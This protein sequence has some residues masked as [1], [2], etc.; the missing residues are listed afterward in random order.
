LTSITGANARTFSYN[1]AGGYGNVTSNGLQDF[2]YNLA[3]QMTG[4][5]SPTVAYQYDGNSRR[6][7]RTEGGQTTYT[8]YSQ[9]GQLLHKEAGGVGT[10][11]MYAGHM[12]VAT[13][14]GSTVNYVHMDL[15][16]S[17]IDGRAGSTN[18]T[19]NYTPWGEKLDNPIPLAGDVGYTGHQSDVATGLTYM[20]ARY[21]D[22]VVGRFM[23]VDP[24]GFS[25][26]DPM[27]FNRYSYANN[28]PY[29]YTDP[30]GMCVEDACVL[31]AAAVRAAVPAVIAA[32]AA[33]AATPVM[34]DLANKIGDAITGNNVGG[35][36]NES[37]PEGGNTS[38]DAP[39]GLV[40]EQDGKSAQQGNRHNSGPLSSDNGGTGDPAK[41]FE[42]L[43]GGQSGPAPEG[44]NYPA[45]TQ[46]G[47][48]GITLR[49]GTDK[50]GPRIDIPAQG[51]KP[52][53]TLHYPK[54]E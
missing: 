4:S 12:L 14:Q 19:E 52:H 41:D 44:S 54:K 2:T 49:P 16:G 38:P 5:T 18:Y 53:E 45:G 47:E 39:S 9:S 42:A 46:V 25:A 1:G 33:I 30:T 27:T 23:A 10:D 36:S 28:N 37:A 15:L 6:V 48:N 8:M 22:P 29:R 34:I 13:K 17:P 35:M 40:G 11:Y 24:V 7:M 51:D 43:T 20:Q 3:G 31:E 26:A 21:Y 32:G 50:A